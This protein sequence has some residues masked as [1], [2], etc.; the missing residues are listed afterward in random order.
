MI[1]SQQRITID[2]INYDKNR[3][4]E[5]TCSSND[6]MYKILNYD[7]RY[8]CESDRNNALYRS[9]VLS[10]PDNKLLS[11][12]TPKTM[13]NDAFIAKYPWIDDNTYINECIEGV[14]VNLFYDNRIDK[15]KISTRNSVGG[16]YWFFRNDRQ[17]THKTFIEMFMECL[18]CNDM[19][20]FSFLN[21]NLSYQFV[22]QHPSNIMVYPVYNPQVFLVAVFEKY[23]NND[24]RYISPYYFS[25]W[26]CFK[27]TPIRFPKMLVDFFYEDIKQNYCSLYSNILSKGVMITRIDT[28]DATCFKNE[29]FEKDNRHKKVDSKLFYQYVCLKRSNK[30]ELFLHHFAHY[31]KIFLNY[32]CI[33]RQYVEALY[34]VYRL[35]YIRKTEIPIVPKFKYHIYRIHN[36][37]YLPSLKTNKTIIITRSVIR[38]YLSEL[39]PMQLYQFLL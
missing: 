31:R 18:N 35:I 39:H 21:S 23:I 11:F 17:R 8:L 9:V 28:G 15:W 26:N 12:S 4:N 22:M 32:S 13:S 34:D 24:I 6:E 36:D 16:N 2:I 1:E 14:M 30:E 37:I 3:I 38:D 20:Y 7:S 27:N 10:Y 33:F 25:Q 19:Q 5:K 29:L